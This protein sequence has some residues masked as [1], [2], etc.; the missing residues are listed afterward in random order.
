MEAPKWF[1][2]GEWTYE[3]RLRE[4]GFFS[5]EKRKL[6]GDPIAV[7]NYIDQRMQIKDAEA[8]RKCTM[9]VQRPQIQ[10][11]TWQILIKNKKN[12]FIV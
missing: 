9:T 2:A 3:E 5:L 11:Q 1:R 8:S 4:L 6:K 7:C 12:Y 10:A